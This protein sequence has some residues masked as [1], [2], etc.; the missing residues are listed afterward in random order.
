[1]SDSKGRV[2]V[3]T[4]LENGSFLAVTRAKHRPGSVRS[5]DDFQQPGQFA[6]DRRFLLVAN[7][8]HET[9]AQI[10]PDGGSR[11]LEVDK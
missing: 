8:R 11:A 3:E 5:E 6:P 10:Q 9:E 1:M 4:A 2:K 7:Q